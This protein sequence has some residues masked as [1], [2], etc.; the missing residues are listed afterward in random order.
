MPSTSTPFLSRCSSTRGAA[1]C[2]RSLNCRPSRR[3]DATPILR[4]GR[5]FKE[6]EHIAAPR[7]EEQMHVRIWLMRGGNVILSKREHKVHVEHA[8]IPQ[9]GFLGVRGAAY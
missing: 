9:H 2:S 5:Q 8:L 1:M 4:H 3:W 6:R 7:V